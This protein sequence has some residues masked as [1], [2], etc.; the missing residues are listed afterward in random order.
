MYTL[1]MYNADDLMEINGRYVL[2]A[3]ARW[4]LDGKGGFSSIS[5]DRST[6]PNTLIGINYSITGQAYVQSFELA[7][8]GRPAANS[9]STG[10]AWC[11]GTGTAARPRRST[12]PAR[13]PFPGRNFQGVAKDGSYLFANSSGLA[14]PGRAARR[15]TS[16][17]WSR[18][19]R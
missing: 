4:S 16:W 18:T 5:I 13:W 11:C 7:P 17:S 19:G 15:S 6:S 3:I 14:I 12:A 10:R 1:W 9:G 2:P 8:D